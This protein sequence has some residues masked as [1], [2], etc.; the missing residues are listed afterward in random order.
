MDLQ[1]DGGCVWLEV[2]QRRT[3]K[4][5]H[6]GLQSTDAEVHLRGGGGGSFIL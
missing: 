4:K 2:L 5:R 1:P 3:K 6:F